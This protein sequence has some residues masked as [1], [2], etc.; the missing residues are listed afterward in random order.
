MMYTFQQFL[1]PITLYQYNFLNHNIIQESLI[2]E[3]RIKIYDEAF[4]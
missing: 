3:F 2:D 1:F 4:P